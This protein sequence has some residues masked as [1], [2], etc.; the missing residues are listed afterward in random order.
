MSSPDSTPESNSVR[1]VV[2]I[3]AMSCNVRVDNPEGPAVV[4]I[5]FKD[6]DSDDHED[7]SSDLEI[8]IETD[9]AFEH[10]KDDKSVR[11]VRAALRRVRQ[12]A[13]ALIYLGRPVLQ[14]CRVALLIANA[15]RILVLRA[16][17][18][19]AQETARTNQ[20]E[21]VWILRSYSAGDNEGECHIF[22]NVKEMHVGAPPPKI[23]N[24]PMSFDLQQQLDLYPDSGSTIMSIQDWFDVN[25]LDETD[26]WD[27]PILCEWCVVENGTA[28][29]EEIRNRLNVEE[30]L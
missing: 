15:V 4:S 13:A 3:P 27:S 18:C 28:C 29:L 23:A 26:F 8:E 9:I 14:S 20:T 21:L 2:L 17:Y 11:V 16:E 22:G 19:N 6:A 7:D 25:L 10:K 12:L 1:E 24:V 5:K 30:K